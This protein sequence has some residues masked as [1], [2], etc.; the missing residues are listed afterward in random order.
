MFN[1][2]NY[3][4]GMG[5]SK[6]NQAKV[7]NI[8]TANDYYDRLKTI[9]L[10]LFEWENLPVS[11]DARFLETVLFDYGKAI[12]IK[13]PALG[14]LSLKCTP[15]G[16]LNFYD[17]PIKYTAYGIGYHEQFRLD[18]CVYIRNNYLD[19]PTSI[20]VQLFANRLTEA[21]RTIDVNIK[22]Q[23]TP[24]MIRCGEKERL[25]MLNIYDKYEGNEPFI[26]EGKALEQG[27]M[28][29]F[30][31]DAPFVA[32][33]VQEYKRQIWNEAMTFFGINN[34]YS[35]DKKERLLTDEINANN[36]QVS[37][38]A[39]SMLITRQEA[40]KKFNELF[41]PEKPLSV[42]MRSFSEKETEFTETEVE[43]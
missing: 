12:F 27:V 22:A 16:E 43:E 28:Q 15:S 25:T 30:K 39:E 21:E 42:K 9:A 34:N 37:I 40:C 24:V 41:K 32:D 31:T 29:V 1:V 11:C 13:D 10:S 26:M 6:D 2:W 5:K 38:M 33:K 35:E 36:E 3:L 19:K 4:T 17:I 7:M 14:I 23:K 8:M 20:T 18:E